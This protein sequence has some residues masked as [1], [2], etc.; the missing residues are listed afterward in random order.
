MSPPMPSASIWSGCGVARLSKMYFVISGSTTPR[1]D[2]M[3]A[4]ETMTIKARVCG[5]R[6][7]MAGEEAARAAHENISQKSEL[8]IHIPERHSAAHRVGP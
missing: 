8:H 1:A 2:A 5:A 4:S 3:S 7:T 6:N